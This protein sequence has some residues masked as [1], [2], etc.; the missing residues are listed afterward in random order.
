M[1][2]AFSRWFIAFWSTKFCKGAYGD[3][4]KPDDAKD[5]CGQGYSTTF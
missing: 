2:S 5:F 3:A 4:V 1:A